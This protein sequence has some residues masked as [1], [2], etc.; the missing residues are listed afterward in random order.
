MTDEPSPHPPITW[1][2]NGE[3]V[4]LLRALGD[5]TDGRILEFRPP[6]SAGRPAR[7][8]LLDAGWT[9]TTLAIGDADDPGHAPTVDPPGPGHDP[10]HVILV[11]TDVTAEQYEWVVRLAHRSPWVLLIGVHPQ[12]DRTP[13]I[14]RLGAAG[15]RACLYDGV[16]LY[17]VA[18][19]HSARLESALSYPACI[20][21][22]V[23]PSASPSLLRD[24][25]R[26]ETAAISSALR[27]K[28][29]AVS[30]WADSSR[31]AAADR[32]ELV[33][34]RRHAHELATE[35]AAIRKTL[36][37]RVTAPLRGVRRLRP[38]RSR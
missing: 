16:F 28:E 4:V 19:D 29:R 21:D 23:L 10:L 8:A 20:R 2:G 25:R 27:W 37:W 33:D 30:A 3:E 1:E 12:Q 11:A 34:L 7:Q 9:V 24:S 13:L 31:G 38:G 14:H 6:E 22:D 17:L 18:A 36:S 5:V 26:R 35:L 15:Y 32:A